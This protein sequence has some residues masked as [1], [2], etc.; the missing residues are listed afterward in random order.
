MKKTV[1]MLATLFAMSS[2]DKLTS[3]GALLDSLPS[4]K[5]LI[6][7]VKHHA[8]EAAPEM[9]FTYLTND[10]N[11]D[12][13]IGDSVKV[14]YV[15][16]KLDSA[17][18]RNEVEYIYPNYVNT[19]RR[20]YAMHIRITNPKSAYDPF[21]VRLFIMTTGRITPGNYPAF[22]F[23][24]GVNTN[25]SEFQTYFGSDHYMAYTPFKVTI[26]GYDSDNILTGTFGGEKVING[27]INVKITEY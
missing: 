10:I 3:E 16:P 5:G 25:I 27:T 20:Q 4:R 12:V 11:G 9:S 13:L 21:Y 22:V 26:T 15:F 17:V 18:A 19:G 6:E 1:I 24:S 7:K 23:G 2:C 8:L 14:D